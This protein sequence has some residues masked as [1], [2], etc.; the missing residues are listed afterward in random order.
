[1]EQASTPSEPASGGEPALRRGISLW[2]M[3][4]YGAGRG[5]GRDPVTAQ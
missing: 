1:M 3:S 4:L 5:N 2:R